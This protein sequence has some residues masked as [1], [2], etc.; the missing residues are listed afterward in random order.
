MREKLLERLAQG[1][2]LLEEGALDVEGMED[3]VQVVATPIGRVAVLTQ[4]GAKVLGQ[5]YQPLTGE[6]LERR[7]LLRA[8]KEA[9]ERAGLKAEQRGEH[10][11]VEGKVLVWPSK[12][13]PPR[14][15]GLVSVG[16]RRRKALANVELGPR[17]KEDILEVLYAHF[18]GKPAD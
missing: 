14:G 11:L 9:L 8:V 15:K 13:N 1:P 16:T 12:R 17:S 3:L 2:L 10:L 18:L 6:R 5:R 7:A 4:K